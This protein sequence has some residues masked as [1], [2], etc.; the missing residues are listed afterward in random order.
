METNEMYKAVMTCYFNALILKLSVEVVKC[1]NAW[2]K[3]PSDS[4]L[5]NRIVVT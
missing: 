1:V 4:H 2:N 5:L 3:L